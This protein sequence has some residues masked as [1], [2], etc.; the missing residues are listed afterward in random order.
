MSAKKSI[1]TVIEEKVTRK[2]SKIHQ[3]SSNS[4]GLRGYSSDAY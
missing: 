4:D 1:A 3:V 2:R